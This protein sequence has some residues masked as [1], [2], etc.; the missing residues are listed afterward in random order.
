MTLLIMTDVTDTSSPLHF[1]GCVFDNTNMLGLIKIRSNVVSIRLYSPPIGSKAMIYFNNSVFTNCIA[2][3]AS[4]CIYA[5]DNGV[6]GEVLHIYINNITAH[7]NF[8]TEKFGNTRAELIKVDNAKELHI[9]GF[10]NF[11]CNFGTAFDIRNT[12]IYLNGQ[13]HISDNN[14]YMGTGFKVQGLSYFLLSNGLNATF[15]NNT[16][17]S[18]G[19]AIYAI[20][21]D[22][23]HKCMF[24]NNTENITNIT[25]TFINNTAAEAG[26]SIYSNNLDQS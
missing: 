16:A 20:A 26:S 8:K 2:S 14:G 11:S 10:N 21:D 23:F 19:G 7:N 22:D 9:N 13:L 24:Q 12:I 6:Q 15:I 4:S 1:N 5:I 18:I 3:T 17:L 25:M